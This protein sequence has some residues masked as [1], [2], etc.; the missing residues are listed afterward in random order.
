MVLCTLF[1]SIAILTLPQKAFATTNKQYDSYFNDEWFNIDNKSDNEGDMLRHG[2]IS[3]PKDY[4]ESDPATITLPGNKS[5]GRPEYKFKLV[6]WQPA[7][8]KMTVDDNYYFFECYETNGVSSSNCKDI[9]VQLT[10]S[11]HNMGI[12]Y[13]G[14]A[15]DWAHAKDWVNAKLSMDDNLLND[16]LK[17]AEPNGTISPDLAKLITEVQ[18][19]SIFGEAFD[20][21]QKTVINSLGDFV[22]SIGKWTINAFLV[23]GDLRVDEKGNPSAVVMGWQKIRDVSNIL[24]V[25]GLLL[26]A[27][28]NVT[29]Y[30]IDYYSAKA[31][32]PRLILAG[33]FINF[34]FLIFQLILN[35]ADI[36]TVYFT[37]QTSFA[38]ILGIG[39]KAGGIAVG[40]TAFIT[41]FVGLLTGGPATWLF[42]IILAVIIGLAVVTTVAILIFRKALLYILVVFS[43]LV[44]LLSVMPFTRGLNKTFWNYFLKYS[45]MGAITAVILFVASKI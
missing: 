22:D 21:V 34:S 26:I 30:Q 37:S 29:R 6:Q 13:K 1:V 4:L 7:Q 3:I 38:D 9:A 20:W 43:P 16:F 24:L 12:F 19:S 14:S 10:E 36:L 33:I 39:L 44:L 17:W 35:F 23:I 32:L 8:G 31:L 28:A 27:L 25:V 15:K 40:S 5:T 11:G 42:A 45:F 18:G 2:Q 41:G